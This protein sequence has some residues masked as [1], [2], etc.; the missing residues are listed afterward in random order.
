MNLTVYTTVCLTSETKKSPVYQGVDRY[1]WGWTQSR[2]LSIPG[3]TNI[4]A[5][6][7]HTAFGAADITAAWAKS[8][9]NSN[10][11]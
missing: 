3:F 1:E 10:I 6:G 11:C 7:S 2:S 8:L 5:I 9:A 4:T